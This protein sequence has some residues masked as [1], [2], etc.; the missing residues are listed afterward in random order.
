MR[1][2]GERR[3]RRAQQESPQGRWIRISVQTREVLEHAVLP[4]QLGRLD[5]LQ[6]ED[7]RIQHREQRFADAVAVV[8][9]LDADCLSEGTLET[10]PTQESIDEVHPAVVSQR[11]GAEIENQISGSLGHCV[12]PY[13]WGRVRRNGQ[14]LS[15]F[16]IQA[17]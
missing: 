14:A 6:P 16:R 2:L 12:Q 5:A 3:R 11:V 8:A 10:N 1:S 7:H 15:V 13:P 9:L 17:A 4:Q